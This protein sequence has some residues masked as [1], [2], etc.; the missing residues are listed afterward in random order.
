MAAEL[1]LTGLKLVPDGLAETSAGIL[2]VEADRGT[3][4][5]TTV[6]RRKVERYAVALAEGRVDE[7]WF[8]VSSGPKRR[9]AIER[10]VVQAGVGHATRVM[11][12]EAVR[13]RPRQLLPPLDG[14]PW[15]F[16]PS[17]PSYSVRGTS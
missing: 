9:A 10:E 3:E 14:T 6:I 7:L 16:G 4:Q 15:R 12:A 17:G 11:G 1:G 13:G 8:A 5:L 2:A